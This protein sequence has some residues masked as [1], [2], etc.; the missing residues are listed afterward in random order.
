[1][2]RSALLRG[3]SAGALALFVSSSLALAQESLPTIDIAGEA[4]ARAKTSGERP[5]SSQNGAGQGGRFTG[6]TADFDTAAATT[7]DRIPIL[8]NPASIKVIPRQLI[9]EKQGVSLEDAL[10]G[11]VAG[12]Q[13]VS[14]FYDQFVIRGFPVTSLTLRNNLRVYNF[15]AHAQAGNLQS[16]EVLKGPA[17]LFYGRF[18]PGGIIN[19]VPKHPLDTPYYSRQAHGVSRA[20]RSTPRA[21]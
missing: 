13:S 21:L 3:A 18:E 10:L 20:R 19:L 4:P 17:S 14:N 6:Y 11:N 2:F 16:V 1:M 9:D 5:A 15:Y 12:V 8:Q 7:K